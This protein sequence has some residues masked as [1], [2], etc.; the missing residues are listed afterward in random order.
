MALGSGMAL[1]FVAAWVQ[2]YL[3]LG[4]MVAV[5]EEEAGKA[6]LILLGGFWRVHSVRGFAALENNPGRR[7]RTLGMGLARGLSLGLVAVCS[8]AAAENLAYL[9]AFPEG[10]VLARL[11][12][13]LPIHLV[14]ALLEALGALLW[15]RGP[16]R[17]PW[18][19]PLAWVVSLA[20]AVGFHLGANHLASSALPFSLFLSGVIVANALFVALLAVYLRQAYLGGFL[21]GAD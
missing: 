15:L 18:V 10:G 21:H 14:S 16:H 3:P 1:F 19:G 8:F 20:A 17:R 6:G 4:P 11:F 12:W 7:A 2:R 13:S 9:L 5:L